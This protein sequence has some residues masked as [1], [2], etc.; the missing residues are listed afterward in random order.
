MMVEKAILIS[1]QNRWYR[2]TLNIWFQEVF[3]L[4]KLLH[5]KEG[6]RKNAFM[7]GG[8]VCDK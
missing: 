4:L 7:E 6:R 8:V 2:V 1:Y 5:S 3:L